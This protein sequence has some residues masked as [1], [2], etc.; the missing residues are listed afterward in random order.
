GQAPPPDAAGAGPDV[1]TAARGRLVELEQAP[2]TAAGVGRVFWR[3]L[4][5]P[6]R[7][8]C[9]GRLRE[10]RRGQGGGQPV[11][12]LPQEEPAAQ[13][14]PPARAG[15]GVAEARRT[16]DA[17]RARAD[18]QRPVGTAAQGR[19]LEPAVAG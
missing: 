6:G 5:G 19:R 11:E 18:R 8:T 12:G 9:P 1:D 17:G 14:A 10:E 13:P 4:R 3:R 15:G 2:A 16:D 7:R